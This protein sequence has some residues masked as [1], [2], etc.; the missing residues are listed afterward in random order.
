MKTEQNNTAARRMSESELSKELGRLQKKQDF[1]SLMLVV[2]IVAAIAVGIIVRSF[3]WGC[4]VFFVFTAVAVLLGGGAQKRKKA[5]IAQELGGDFG[6]ELEHFFGADPHDPTLA[7][8]A[9]TLRELRLIAACWEECTI[10]DAH[11]GSWQGV[12]FAA[13]NAVLCHSYEEKVGQDWMTQTTTV[14]RGLVLRCRTAGTAHEPVW[15]Y[16]RAEK[17]GGG[18][19]TENARFNERFV[20]I[21]EREND[22]FLLLTPQFMETLEELERRTRGE[23]SGL[24]WQ[25]NTL[26]LALTTPYCFAQTSDGVNARDISALRRSFTD[27]LTGMTQ[28]LGILFRNTVLFNARK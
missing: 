4:V 25:G 6:A 24:C 26:S 20:I 14:F 19:M 17:E 22:A 15:V 7:I 10:E 8:T 11:G 12:P 21:A 1:W 28:I 3:V 16:R 27:T 18:I 9:D 5:L 23:L 13:G 2:G